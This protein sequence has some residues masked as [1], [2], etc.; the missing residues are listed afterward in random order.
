VEHVYPLDQ[1]KEAFKQS[2]KPNRS[3]KILYAGEVMGVEQEP[4]APVGNEVFLPLETEP[5]ESLSVALSRAFGNL[6]IDPK[7]RAAL[8]SAASR[9]GLH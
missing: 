8:P 1:F 9:S 2:L 7:F 3:G 5:V 6:M 4:P